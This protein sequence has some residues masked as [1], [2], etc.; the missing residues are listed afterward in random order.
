MEKKIRKIFSQRIYVWSNFPLGIF[1]IFLLN[2]NI[3]IVISIVIRWMLSTYFS[4]NSEPRDVFLQMQTLNVHTVV[5]KM[6]MSFSWT[7]VMI[8]ARF[9]WFA[10]GITNRVVIN[11]TSDVMRGTWNVLYFLSLHQII[12][13][14]VSSM[15]VY[16]YA[17]IRTYV[18]SCLLACL[19]VDPSTDLL[20][21]QLWTTCW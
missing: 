20:V 8:K 12:F 6:R 1:K 10:V 2:R 11:S 5:D 17:C 9:V 14:Y 13:V 4:F 21:G 19:L 7:W 18:R 3:I 16:V 15:F